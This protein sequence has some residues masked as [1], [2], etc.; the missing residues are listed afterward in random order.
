MTEFE[1]QDD[2]KTH[3]NVYSKSRS[4]LGRLLSNFANTPIVF[5]GLKFG[6]IESWWYWMK[7]NNINET[8]LFPIFEDEQI[9]LIREKIGAV[10]KSYFRSLYK[11]D[12]SDFS[13]AKEELKEVY[14]LKL[15]A[16]PNIKEMLIE[17]KLPIDHYYVMFDKKVATEGTM[18]T[19]KLW[20]EIKNEL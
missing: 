3:I 5:K 11:S 4:V 15:E 2:G 7:M 6:S 14:K 17:N 18:W 19:A 12:S 9:D 16:H 20:E 10:A 1:I 8:G 13:P